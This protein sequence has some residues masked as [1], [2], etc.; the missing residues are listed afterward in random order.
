MRIWLPVI[1]REFE[2]EAGLRAGNLEHLGHLWHAYGFSQQGFDAFV[3]TDLATGTTRRDATEQTMRSRTVSIGELEAM[4]LSGELR[5][6][7][8]VAA[9]GLVRLR[10]SLP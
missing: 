9:W 6:A 7:P 1:P 3:T 2:E 10:E 5:D 8:S 4:I